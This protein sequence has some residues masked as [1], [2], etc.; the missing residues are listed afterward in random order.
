[1]THIENT[2]IGRGEDALHAV[3]S[4]AMIQH[5]EASVQRYKEKR[6]NRLFAKTI[7]YEVRKL[8]AEKRPRIKV[9]YVSFYNA[10]STLVK[11]FKS[12]FNNI[13]LFYC[14]NLQGRFVKRN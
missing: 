12:H 7:R 8:N 5:R 14:F 11:Y 1:M 13:P 10:F 4:N 3:G 9:I 6:R 2:D